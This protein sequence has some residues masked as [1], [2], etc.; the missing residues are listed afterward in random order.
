[1]NKYL[2]T[3]DPCSKKAIKQ[4]IKQ[5]ENYRKIL[6]TSWILK[7]NLSQNEIHNKFNLSKEHSY[8]IAKVDV[9]YCQGFLAKN[10]WEW[11]KEDIN[12]EVEVGVECC[13]ECGRQTS[14]RLVAECGY[15]IVCEQCVDKVWEDSFHYDSDGKMVSMYKEYYN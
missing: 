8:I 3:C 13:E 2:I 5:F 12:M 10:I 7:S 15:S 11:F 6:K 14:N 1:M 4:G 9:N